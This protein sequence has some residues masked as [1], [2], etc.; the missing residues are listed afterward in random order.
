[1][2]I[3]ETIIEQKKS[4]VKN[5]KSVQSMSD[6]EKSNFFNRNTLSLKKFLLDETR[7]GIIAEFKRKS[8][9]KG[10]INDNADVVEITSAYANNG[11]SALSVLTD[12]KFFG[13][14]ADD[15]MKAR[16]N[17]IPIL[18][19]DFIIDEYQIAEARSIGADIILL[20]A[21]CLAP[22]E[23]KT[24]ARFAK[25][26]QL[27]VLLELHGEEE[28]QHICDETEIIGINNRNLKTFEVDIERSLRMAEKIPSEKIKVAESGISSIENINLFKKHGFRGFLIGENF[29]K[30]KNPAIAFASF[31][32]KLKTV[33]S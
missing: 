29:M 5:R 18:R 32:N 16:I 28:L 14:G 10:M 24:L 30:E 22:Q 15:L 11:A 8:P 9:S 21:A 2:N 31:V 12:E 3:L 20:I 26:L 25:S 27:E 7:T 1:M 13:G 6:L 4:E 17:Q 23:V 33:S 19:K